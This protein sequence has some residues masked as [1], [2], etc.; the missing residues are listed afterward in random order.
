MSSFKCIFPPG[1]LRVHQGAEGI[2]KSFPEH[3]G[4]QHWECASVG[5]HLS[6]PG[7]LCGQI[8]LW[9]GGDLK[10]HGCHSLH[11]VSQALHQ[12]GGSFKESDAQ[13]TREMEQHSCH[14][15]P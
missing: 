10:I 14:F 13:I 7:S 11:F 12:E 9:S 1:G 3:G 2:C 5:F 8:V 4:M 15:S 6:S